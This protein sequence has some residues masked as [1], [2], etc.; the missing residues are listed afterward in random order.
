MNNSGFDEMHIVEPRAAGI[1]VHKRPRNRRGPVGRRLSQSQPD[2]TALP[3]RTEALL[4]VIWNW[5][6]PRRSTS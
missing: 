6:C 4:R 3:S 2:A 5:N 1:D